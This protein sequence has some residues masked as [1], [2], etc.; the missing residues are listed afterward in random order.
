M[1]MTL[2]KNITTNKLILKHVIPKIR[3][4]KGSFKRGLG[5]GGWVQTGFRDRRIM[6]RLPP[7]TPWRDVVVQGVRGRSRTGALPGFRDPAKG[8]RD[9]VRDIRHLIPE[10]GKRFT[11]TEGSTVDRA[12][13]KREKTSTR[14][15]YIS[16]G[17]SSKLE[18]TCPRDRGSG[19]IDAE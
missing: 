12:R 14:A 11:H 7:P 13:W 6:M 3:E 5:G 18:Q 16:S 10:P 8:G 1:M 2:T 15:Y 17:Q 9:D 19:S 4:G